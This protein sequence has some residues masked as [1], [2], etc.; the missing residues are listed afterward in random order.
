MFSVRRFT[1]ATKPVNWFRVDDRGKF[2]WPGF[3]DNMRVLKWIIDRV[4]GKVPARETPA[5][6]VPRLEDLDMTGLNL[7]KDKLERL[8]AVN[9]KDWKPEVD[10]VRTFLKPYKGRLPAEI[11][12]QYEK[13]ERQ[14]R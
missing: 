13:L 7:A 12:E 9:I 6:L 8:F 3:G 14:V 4:T 10:E 5:G 11:R 1:R 2:I